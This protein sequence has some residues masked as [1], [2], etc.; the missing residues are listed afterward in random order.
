MAACAR[1]AISSRAAAGWRLS[2]ANRDTPVFTTAACTPGHTRCA[3]A[4]VVS[5]PVTSTTG[6]PY[7]S[8][9]S[10]LMPDSPTTSPFRLT[11]AI[12]AGL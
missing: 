9:T 5:S 7:P 8:A 10:A 1:A 6:T 12:A 2:A 4:A 11:S 3:S